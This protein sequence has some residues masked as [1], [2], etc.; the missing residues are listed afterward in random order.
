MSTGATRHLL[1]RQGRKCRGDPHQPAGV[2]SVHGEWLHGALV[3]ERNV[4]TAMEFSVTR[5]ILSGRHP[6]EA[7]T[8]T[9]FFVGTSVYYG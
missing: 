7:F 3:G 4:I 5:M 8:I 6:V 9:G 1:V 2:R